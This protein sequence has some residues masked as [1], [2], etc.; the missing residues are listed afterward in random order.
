MSVCLLSE[1][2][3]GSVTKG[4]AVLHAVP[5]QLFLPTAY[6][7]HCNSTCYCAAKTTCL[8]LTL[9]SK[10]PSSPQTTPKSLHTAS[11]PRQSQ[12]ALAG[13]PGSDR[14]FIS[15]AAP[16]CNVKFKSFPLTLPCLVQIEEEAVLLLTGLLKLAEAPARAQLQRVLLNLCAHPDSRKQVMQILMSMLRAPLSA[17]EAAEASQV[18]LHCSQQT[19]RHCVTGSSITFGC[20]AFPGILFGPCFVVLQHPQ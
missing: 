8:P 19:H 4:C 12:Q 15:K 11:H 1:C 2:A 10:P 14:Q 3:W 7:V 18:S 9:A 16:S 5:V 17:D 20:S 6:P 13:S